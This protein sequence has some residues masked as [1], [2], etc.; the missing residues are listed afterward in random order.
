MHIYTTCRDCGDLL[1]IT[2]MDDTVHPLCEPQP[3]KIERLTDAW[4]DLI[5][6]DCDANDQQLE[7]IEKQINELNNRPPRL[8][9]AALAY[10][11]WGWP[12]FPLKPRSKTPATRNGFK[13]ATINLERI[14]KW[15]KANPDSNIGLPTGINFDVI[16]ID[17]PNGV[18][19]YLDLVAEDLIPDVHGRVCTSSGGSHL[20]IK[21][22]GDRNR[23]GL[24]PGIDYRGTGGY[25]VAPP[26]ISSPGNSW[27]W[28]NVPSPEIKGRMP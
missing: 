11:G 5:K 25:V 2:D 17:P 7:R 24:R 4:L 19:S 14:D 26:S 3:T 13:D 20:Y 10:A 23:T 28:I 1:L 6:A 27:S 9:E 8:R 16:D 12:V 22:T 21:K 15:W 18:Q